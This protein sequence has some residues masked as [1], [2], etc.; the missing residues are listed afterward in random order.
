[1]PLP[2]ISDVYR[3]ALP[4]T[5]GGGIGITPVNVLHFLAPTRTASD[6]GD[7]VQLRL[8]TDGSNMF[9][10]LYSG[11]TLDVLQVLKL[12]G[13]SATVDVVQGGTVAGS[14]SGG[15]VP[16]AATV[17]SLHTTQRGS[18]GRGRTYVGPMGETQFTDGKVATS[19]VST[20]TSAWNSFVSA[21][22]LLSPA[23]QLVVASYKHSSAHVVTNLRVD[24]MAGTQRRR[25]D[26]LR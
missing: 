6:V 10:T 12:D 3:V 14:G 4:W 8:Q 7:K 1:M 2:V 23:I 26:A 22:A 25:Q 24:I 20:M 9:D 15:V 18:Q 21:L 5:D 16:A 13:T 19:S 17:V 11:Y